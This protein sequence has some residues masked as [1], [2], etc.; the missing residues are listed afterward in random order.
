MCHPLPR[1]RPSRPG[2]SRAKKAKLGKSIIPGANFFFGIFGII[3]DIAHWLVILA[4]LPY[5]RL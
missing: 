3:V 4:K 2:K 5:P 1:E